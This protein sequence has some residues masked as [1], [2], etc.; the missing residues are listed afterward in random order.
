MMIAG[1]SEEEVIE[2]FYDN[3]TDNNHSDF[4]IQLD[5]F[6]YNRSLIS[7]FKFIRNLRK[8]DMI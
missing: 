5:D 4:M 1:L 6:E 7:V 3:L 8:F 2:K